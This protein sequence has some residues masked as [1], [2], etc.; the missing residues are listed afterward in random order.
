MVLIT[1]FRESY[2]SGLSQEALDINLIRFRFN[3][4]VPIWEIPHSKPLLQLLHLLQRQV[5]PTG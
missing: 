3:Q 1:I 4:Q 5:R 2:R